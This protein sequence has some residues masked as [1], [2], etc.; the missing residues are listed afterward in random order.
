MKKFFELIKK[1]IKKFFGFIAK[2]AKK[3]WKT[4]TNKWLLKW[5]TTLI[6]VVLVIAGYVG[7]NLAAE[8][9]KVSDLDFTTKKLYT[10]SEKT[11]KRLKSL[12]NNITI[13]LINMGDDT[14]INEYTEKYE[15]ESDR[16]KVEKI[17]DLSSR[18]D[19]QTKYNI[20][21]TDNLIVVKNGEKE[22]QITTSDLVTY[23]YSTGETIDRTEE[24]ITNAIVEVTIDKKPHIYVLSGKT[25]NQPERS[26]GIVANKLIDEANEMDL[27]DILTKGSVPEDCDCLIITTLK[28]DLTD[29]ERDK[30]L[31][32]INNGGNILVLSSNGTLDVETPNFDKILEQYGIT[33]GYGAI[34]EQDSSKM[35]YDTPNMV[36]SQASASFMS[37]IDMTLKLIL[38]NPGKIQFA[39]ETKLEELGVTYE[40][41]ASTSEKSFVRTKFDISSTSRTEQDSEEGSSI[42]GALATKKISDDK[43]SELI[44]YSDETCASTS[45]LI[46]GKQLIS[47]VMLYNNEDIVLNSVSH[48]TERTDTITIRKTDEAENYTV[49]EQEDVVIK[50]IIFV[51]P[52]II[53]VIGGGVWVYRRRRI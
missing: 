31:E 49:T 22:K 34:L 7:I 52:V 15:R 35:L 13:E 19:L 5:T 41:I 12:E 50:T 8:Q 40:T 46:I 4:I 47:A 17:E 44:I 20:G 28:E 37:D 23:D 30:I 38:V 33:L 36:V 43:K 32:Y 53:I 45:Q 48:L 42:V 6:L 16:V 29:L 18:V 2:I 9:I 14:Y 10:L 11:K 21:T 51:V 1:A 26:L 25:Y 3:L 39:D 27:L 24:A